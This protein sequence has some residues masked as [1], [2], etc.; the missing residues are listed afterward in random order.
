[1][2]S[3]FGTLEEVV[4][5]ARF[6]D[7]DLELRR[8][9]HI[10][11]DDGEWYAFISDAQDHLEAFYR[12]YGCELVTRSDGFFY[13]LPTSDRLSRRHLS[14][15]EMLVG[16]TLALQ[17]LDPA[18][19]QSGGLVSREQV[20]SRLTGLVGERELAGALEPRRRRF[21]DERIVQQAIREG[22]GK[23]LR[24]LAAMGFIELADTER[25]RLRAPVLRFAEPVRG[26]GDTA[27]ALE[28]LIARGEI[29]EPGSAVGE[30]SFAYDE[31]NED[32][33]EGE[34]ENHSVDGDSVS[35]TGDKEEGPTRNA[36]NG[37]DSA[38]DTQ[39]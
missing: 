26:L 8:G 6:P 22:V 23:A 27:R 17:Y 1:V 5:D 33:A 31:E 12:R 38:G 35:G 3:R 24:R 37:G 25:L 16:Q 15:G 7:V 34:E 13:L 20:L 9:R 14:A 18:T 19:V 28:R 36:E 11:R 39:G 4:R 30:D 32:E 2:T 10:D 29:I 21:D